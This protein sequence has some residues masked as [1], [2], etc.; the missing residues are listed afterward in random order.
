MGRDSLAEGALCG[1][2]WVA[3]AL[4]RVFSRTSI[5]GCHP[6][7]GCSRRSR[8]VDATLAQGVRADRDGWM[9]PLPRVFAPIA[10]GGC[11]PCRG[12]SR[13]SRRVDA[14]LAQGVRA[15]RDGWM[16]PLPRVF[17]P[18]ATGGCHPCRGCW[19][20]SRW[21]IPPFKGVVAQSPWASTP[22]N[23]LLRA[24]LRGCCQPKAGSKAH[25][26]LPGS[27]S[28]PAC[29]GPASPPACRGPASPPAC[30][31]QPHLLPAG[32]LLHLQPAGGLLH[33]LPAGFSFTSCLPGA[34]FTS[35][36]PGSFLQRQRP[37]AS[38]APPARPA[39]T[40]NQ[41]R[42]TRA[43]LPSGTSCR[44]KNPPLTHGDPAEAGPPGQS[45]PSRVRPV[46]QRAG[47]MRTRTGSRPSSTSC[48]SPV[49]WI[50]EQLRTGRGGGR[51]LETRPTSPRLAVFPGR[52]HRN[53]EPPPPDAFRH[54]ALLPARSPAR[55]FNSF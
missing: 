34:C 27:A 8:R 29:R 45:Q 35:C 55:W 40:R 33:L 48:A 18:I 4:P 42:Q 38:R 41:A 1:P 25:V 6:C 9:P 52:N 51:H 28:P 10:T 7:P 49:A 37:P 5:G 17:A 2:R 24:A 15:D 22:S 21:R 32:G 43:L 26:C 31:V 12:C 30:R 14:T 36:L 3:T 44:S 46:K 20:R 39:A 11:H 23:R 13:R 47:A 50:C 53:G 54:F 16:P 19:R